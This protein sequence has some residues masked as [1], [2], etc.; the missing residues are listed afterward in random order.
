MLWLDLF[1]RLDF[2]KQTRRQ[3]HACIV[4]DDRN[5]SP[6][7]DLVQYGFLKGSGAYNR[8][9]GIYIEKETVIKIDK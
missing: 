9:N 3:Y 5:I 2:L 8:D 7:K 4:V 6:A 1:F